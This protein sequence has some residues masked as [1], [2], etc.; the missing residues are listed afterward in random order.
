MRHMLPLISC[1]PCGDAHRIAGGA[2]AGV[3]GGVAGG[4]GGAGGVTRGLDDRAGGAGGG[5]GGG[6]GGGVGGVAGARALGVSARVD[7]GAGVAGGRRR[8]GRGAAT[9]S[10]SV[11]CVCPGPVCRRSRPRYTARASKEPA[12]ARA[13]PRQAATC[14]L[15]SAVGRIRTATSAAP[16]APRSDA[17]PGSAWSP[18]RS[19]TTTV[20]KAWSA[21]TPRTC[22][23]GR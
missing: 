6:A 3:A 16:A 7:G 13:C 19:Q 15:T 22:A 12:M 20:Q 21:T 4:A 23:S 14:A 5:V 11:T 9:I 8:G 18:A 1:V 17:W 2:G 10:T